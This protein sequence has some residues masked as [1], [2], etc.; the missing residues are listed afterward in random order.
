MDREP[1]HGAAEPGHMAT[2]VQGTQAD[3]QGYPLLPGRVRR[4]MEPLECR[5]IMHPPEGQFQDQGG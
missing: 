3:E 5:R 4:G 1:C 2:R